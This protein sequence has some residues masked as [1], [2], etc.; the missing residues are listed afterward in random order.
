M[1]SV[2][3]MTDIGRGETGEVMRTMLAI[4]RAAV[5]AKA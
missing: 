4:R 1:D 5:G 3:R 2:P